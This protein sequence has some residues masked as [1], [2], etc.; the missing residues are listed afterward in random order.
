MRHRW[1]CGQG[2][3]VP[4]HLKQVWQEVGLTLQYSSLLG[5][6]LVNSANHP[7]SSVDV[8]QTPR[9]RPSFKKEDL[10]SASNENNLP[11]LLHVLNDQLTSDSLRLRSICQQAGGALLSSREN[12]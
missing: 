11:L 6:K 4:V 10:Q 5:I 7:C 1:S 2:P 8:K 12:S 9:I 3:L